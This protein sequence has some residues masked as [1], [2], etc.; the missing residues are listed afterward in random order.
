MA[1]ASQWLV[2]FAM[3]VAPVDVCQVTFAIPAPPEAVPAREAVAE[4][5]VAVFETGEVISTE[6]G[7]A[8]TAVAGGGGAKEIIFVPLADPRAES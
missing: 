1:G 8:G 4:L 2:P 3:P 7:E 5:I 6:I